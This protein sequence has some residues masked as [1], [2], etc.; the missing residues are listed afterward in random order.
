LANRTA[1]RAVQQ[2]AAWS[3]TSIPLTYKFTSYFLVKI[4]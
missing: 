2:I 3:H 1:S 4:V